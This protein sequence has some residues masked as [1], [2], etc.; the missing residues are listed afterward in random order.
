MNQWH[1]L[2]IYVK[3]INKKK[4]QNPLD[5]PIGKVSRVSEGETSFI[6]LTT[7]SL[8]FYVAYD[9]FFNCFSI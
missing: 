1:T 6:I 9:F 3:L 5:K 8:Q 4:K 2:K 7:R